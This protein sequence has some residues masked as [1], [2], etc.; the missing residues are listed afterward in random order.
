MVGLR[1]LTVRDFF[2]TRDETSKS[3]SEQDIAQCSP[4]TISAKEGH[5]EITRILGKLQ[6][7]LLLSQVF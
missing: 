5:L 3:S 7:D 2:V 4:W 6:A 1:H